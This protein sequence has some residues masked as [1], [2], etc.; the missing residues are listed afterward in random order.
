LFENS[1]V[2]R[3]AIRK[4]LTYEDCAPAD[5]RIQ[6]ILGKYLTTQGS[7]SLQ[8]LNEKAA[9]RTLNQVWMPV[10][11]RESNEM[12]KARMMKAMESTWHAESLFLVTPQLPTA[13][14]CGPP[15]R[16]TR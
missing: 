5:G 11:A 3:R 16:P 9:D 13:G 10:A 8:R 6:L 15:A 1:P 7:G 12:R 4:I 14:N 2:K